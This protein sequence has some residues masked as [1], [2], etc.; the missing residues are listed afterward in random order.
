MVDY[1]TDEKSL[2]IVLSID[3]I[4]SSWCIPG[5]LKIYLFYDCIL[6]SESDFDVFDASAEKV[7]KEKKMKNRLR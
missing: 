5:R 3:E 7:K 1:L 6:Q 2:L 4:Q